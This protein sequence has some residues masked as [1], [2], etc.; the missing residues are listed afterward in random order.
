MPYF[1]LALTIA[2][3]LLLQRS[4]RQK[5]LPYKSLPGVQDSSCEISFQ[6]LL[7]KSS[8]CH[9]W[10]LYFC[11]EIDVILKVDRILLTSRRSE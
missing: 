9:N 10:E 5:N 4:Q 7:N 6:C 11:L 1:P 8:S 3:E 2:C